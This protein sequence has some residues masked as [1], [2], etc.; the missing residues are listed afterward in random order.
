MPM[1]CDRS[2]FCWPTAVWTEERWP[3]WAVGVHQAFVAPSR[4]RGLRRR[5]DST[6]RQQRWNGTRLTCRWWWTTNCDQRTLDPRADGGGD[7]DGC[8]VYRVTKSEDRPLRPLSMHS[9]PT[10]C[11]FLH[12]YCSIHHWRGRKRINEKKHQNSSKPTST[13][14][15]LCTKLDCRSQSSTLDSTLP[16]H[17]DSCWA[18]CFVP[19]EVHD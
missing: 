9:H 19:I 18:H 7:D 6:P 10:S 3:E 12:C 14:P 11:Y 17:V 15:L 16:W 5:C 8:S 13:S 2:P 4:T 1:A